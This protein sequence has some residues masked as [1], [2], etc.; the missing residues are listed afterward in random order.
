MIIYRMLYFVVAACSLIQSCAYCICRKILLHHYLLS[1]ACSA[2]YALEDP[3]IP[4]ELVFEVFC[5]DRRTDVSRTFSTVISPLGF[6]INFRDFTGSLHV[7]V[8]YRIMCPHLTRFFQP[9]YEKPVASSHA[10]V[11]VGRPGQNSHPSI[12][13]DCTVEARYLATFEWDGFE[14]RF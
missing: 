13:I 8:S 4:L 1:A 12:R 6:R 5:E 9:G 3:V 14:L 11:E 7:R 2:C 10:F